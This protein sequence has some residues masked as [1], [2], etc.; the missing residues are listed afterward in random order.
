MNSRAMPIATAWSR[1]RSYRRMVWVV[2]GT[3]AATI[4]IW[5]GVAWW[6]GSRP[7]ARY[8][9][10]LEAFERGKTQTL[11]PLSRELRSTPG[12]EPHGHLLAGLL[13]ARSGRP[14]EAL[15]QL[16]HAA[17]H[18][19]TAVRALTAAAEC[20]YLTGHLVEAKEASL[21][22]L[23]RDD[24]ALEARRWLA[25]AYYDLGASLHAID[26]LQRISVEDGADPRPHRLL[27]LLFK[28]QDQFSRAVVHY[29]HA[30]ER[31]PRPSDAAEM[32]QEL[33]ESLVKLRR[34]DE[35][36]E[37]LGECDETP[38][39]LSLR[40]ECLFAT[41]RT[42]EAQRAVERTLEFAPNHLH[43]LKLKGA[44]LMSIHQPAAAAQVLQRAV[45]AHPHDGS[46]HFQLSQAYARLG[47][48]NEALAQLEL[49]K[50]TQAVERELL[51]LHERAMNEID[52]ADVRFR[53]GELSRWL[54][55]PKMALL[56]FN[57]ALS[58]D[59]VH[60]P[61]RAALD[62]IARNADAADESP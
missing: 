4:V 14:V 37:T 35:A 58:I 22:A 49:M 59:P 2:V 38:D 27:G 43:A 39:I 33:A 34:F 60:E 46:A 25:A 20:Y 17:H 24:S 19:A 9:R 1:N 23:A 42:D 47:K 11:F 13:L 50:Q 53:I 31:H 45:R 54:H 26:E 29:R 55:R 44:I 61:A 51:E 28:D 40:A 16:K 48:S 18:D 52:N 15:E 36:L 56:W 30:L 8:Q 6:Q 10:G 57:A 62:E 41:D 32:R 3:L 5:V 7:E 21:A 12:Y